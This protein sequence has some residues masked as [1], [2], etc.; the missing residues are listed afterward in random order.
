MLSIAFI[1]HGESTDNL[2]S[3]RENKTKSSRLIH[4]RSFRFGLDGETPLC[5]SLVSG[6]A[7]TS[8]L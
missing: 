8:R 5:Q 4:L 7:E 2:V 6:I 1:R 3:N